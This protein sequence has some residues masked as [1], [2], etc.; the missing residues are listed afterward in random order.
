[1][2]IWTL[3]AVI[4]QSANAIRT[5]A[6]LIT[7][8]TY[9]EW[10]EVIMHIDWPYIHFLPQVAGRFHKYV[11]LLKIASH[12]KLVHNLPENRKTN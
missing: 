9:F 7:E 8:C 3:F 2:T 1:M 11:E 6:E 5:F 10:R 12:Q 4:T